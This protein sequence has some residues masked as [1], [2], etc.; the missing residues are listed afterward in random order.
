MDRSKPKVMTINITFRPLPNGRSPFAIC[1]SLGR[2]VYAQDQLVIGGLLPFRY[3]M[4]LVVSR[5]HPASIQSAG[6]SNT[7]AAVST[8]GASAV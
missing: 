5:L 6:L 8:T 4:F 3:Q 7:E 1:T 2:M